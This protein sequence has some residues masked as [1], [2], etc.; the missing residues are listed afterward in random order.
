MILLE[1]SNALLS[2]V[3]IAEVATGIPI[4]P[5]ID[6]T[7]STISL[8]IPGIVVIIY[9]RSSFPEKLV[10]STVP[11]YSSVDDLV[12]CIG[13]MV[14]GIPAVDSMIS[15]V[16][17]VVSPIV[18]VIYVVRFGPG[19]LVILLPS[20]TNGSPWPMP[21]REGQCCIHQVRARSGGLD[22]RSKRRWRTPHHAKYEKELADGD[23]I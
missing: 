23:E 8:L 15:T 20:L 18:F 12:R 5:A 21:S 13:A 17:L 3:L 10:I 19:V 4:V 11:D 6:S 22:G 1:D 14:L 7:I 2:S 9:I 16:P